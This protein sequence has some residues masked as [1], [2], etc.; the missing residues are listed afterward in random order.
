MAFREKDPAK[1][2]AEVMESALLDYMDK[3]Q[4]S[5]V[6][7]MRSRGLGFSDYEAPARGIETDRVFMEAAKKLIPDTVERY[8]IA[9]KLYNEI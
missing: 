8:T 2:E 5:I 6:K 9:L 3:L 7:K 1:K 4:K